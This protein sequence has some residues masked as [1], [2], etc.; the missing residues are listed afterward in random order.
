MFDIRGNEKKQRKRIN[1]KQFWK[2]NLE[3]GKRGGK[4]KHVEYL[5]KNSCPGA[6]TSYWGEIICMYMCIYNLVDHEHCFIFISY[7]ITG[8]CIVQ[9]YF[10]NVYFFELTH[11]SLNWTTCVGRVQLYSIVKRKERVKYSILTHW[12][13]AYTLTHY[14]LFCQFSFHMDGFILVLSHQG[15]IY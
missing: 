7:Y 13:H 11:F 5:K 2:C 12:C 6:S 1:R 8:V 10:I 3:S 15:V 14:N 4:N 9:L